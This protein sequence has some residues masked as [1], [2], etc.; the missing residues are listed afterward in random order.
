MTFLDYFW[1]FRNQGPPKEEQN[2]IE[3]QI[4]TWFVS[5]NRYASFRDLEPVFWLRIS[6]SGCRN[7]F[8]CFG[9]VRGVERLRE[10]VSG[11]F[12]RFLDRDVRELVEGA[13]IKHTACWRPIDW[14]ESGL[15]LKEMVWTV[16]LTLK[17]KQISPFGLLCCK[18]LLSRIPLRLGKESF[19]TNPPTTQA[20][21]GGTPGG[22]LGRGDLLNFGKKC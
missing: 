18:R 13:H 8:F 1:N 14:V 15:G 22:P 6:H 21:Q 10:V 3:Y 17:P 2:K 9:E 19:A 11:A 16:Q 12:G 5:V 20:A 4:R 7:T